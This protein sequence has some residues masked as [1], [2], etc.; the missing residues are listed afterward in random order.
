VNNVEKERV[1]VTNISVENITSKSKEIAKKEL[2][3]ED[4]LSTCKY[5]SE[6]IEG[7]AIFCPFCGSNLNN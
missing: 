5:C 7:T 1:K 3:K 4:F 6:K 2:N